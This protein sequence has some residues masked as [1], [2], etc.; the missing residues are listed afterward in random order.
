MVNFVSNDILVLL[1]AGA[2]CNAGILNS[3]QMISAIEKDLNEDEWREYKPLFHYV[4]SVHYQKEILQGKKPGDVGFN[5][6][7]LVSFLDIIIKISNSSEEPFVFVGTWEKRLIKFI[8]AEQESAFVSNFREKIINKIRG[9]W[10]QP[11]NWRQNSA[12]YKRLID[13]KDELDGVTLEIFSLNYDLCVEHNLKDEAFEDGFD[14]NGIWSFR[15]Y[16]HEGE[17]DIGYYLYKLHGSLN[18][19]KA[20]NG[21]LVK[22]EGH[23][24]TNE[25]AIIFGV[26]NKLQSL[27]PYLFYFYLFREHCLNAKLIV[28]SGYGFLDEHINDVIS[29]AFRDIPNKKLVINTKGESSEDVK[30]VV[31]ERLHIEVAQIEVFLKDASDF[32]HNDLKRATFEPLF[33]NEDA[34][35]LPE[36]FIQDFDALTPE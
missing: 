16:D 22:T 5:I 3:N 4:Q 11:P 6:E 32:F 12:Y 33:A 24:D 18:W 29:Q 20:K 14:E 2:S 31:S 27:D 8:N 23:I 35:E 1:G 28:T 26:D 9:P 17:T 30:K 25:L 10:L 7:N 13:F 21:P 36:G 19:K 15:R 34:D